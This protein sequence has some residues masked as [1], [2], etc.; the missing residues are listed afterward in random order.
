MIKL[1]IVDD[2]PLFREFLRTSIHWEEYGFEICCE[3]KNGVEALEMAKVY[4]PDVVLTDI[5]MPF[6]DGLEL[7]SKLY[8]QNKDIGIVLITGHSEFE[9]ARKAVKIGVSDYIL[10]PFEKEELILTLLKLKDNIRVAVE[11]TAP[12]ML[13]SAV[14]EKS[15]LMHLLSQDVNYHDP[16]LSRQ[17][18]QLGVGTHGQHYVV[19]VIEIDELD[20]KWTAPDEQMLWRFAVSNI[21]NEMLDTEMT[22][23]SFY[24][25]EGHVV[26][27]F[28]TEKA[29]P[30]IGK[31]S[32]PSKVQNLDTTFLALSQSSF[33]RLRMLVNKYLSF[34]VTIGVGQVYSGLEGI[35]RS[36]TEALSALNAKFMLGSNQ[37]I[38]YN[39]LPQESKDFSFYN[40][41]TTESLLI[42]LRS[43]DDEQTQALLNDIF[44]NIKTCQLSPE[45]ARVIYMGLI[46][47]LLSFI[48]QAGK[49]IG[50]IM[51]EAYEPY[52]ELEK[53]STNEL[54]QHYL[55]TIY[56]R[57]M[58]FMDSNKDSRS[59]VIT[60][61]AKTYIH[62]HFK[63][64]DLNIT[65]LAG[66][67]F[68]NQTYLRA[69]FKKEMHMTINDYIT[70]Y[71]LEKAKE[72]LTE[73]F[74]RLSD[75]AEMVGY[76]DSSYFSK[77]F[78][79]HYG[80]SPS[81]YETMKG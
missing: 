52:S 58:Q 66:A 74:Y 51:G 11:V 49:N 57:V 34:G 56:E 45:Y 53:L 31:S 18:Y 55:R 39:Q 72:Y 27:L 59:S 75:I 65:D 37:V 23:F 36:Y 14:V 17:L 9:Y 21:A 8:E 81:Q 33:E 40:A 48:T 63:E 32:E 70:R 22:H 4:D 6:M 78:K 61:K 69:M 35:K 25:Y 62:T 29:T 7:S 79:K 46:S 41:D 68:I 30:P 73:G 43:G 12:P 24:D 77:S 10:K 76:S 50:V 20:Q 38:L 1:M 67:L 71:R 28:E 26:L 60:D 64:N 80:I 3:A 54:H 13:N 47:L 42:S 19:I 16:I 5:S 15:I 2:E 44:N